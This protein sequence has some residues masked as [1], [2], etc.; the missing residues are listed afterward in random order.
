M[1]AEGEGTEYGYFAHIDRLHGRRLGF[2]IRM[3]NRAIQR[4]GL[5]PRRVVEEAANM[6][7]DPDID[8]AWAL[9]DHDRRQDILG[10][11]AEACKQ[12]VRTALSH[13]AF[14]LWLLLHFRDQ[15]PGAQGG[16][17]GGRAARTAVTRQPTYTC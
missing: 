11:C 4:N 13:P 10:V 3:P 5:S 1:V 6:A 15:L 8:E 14:E 16:H 12:A 17:N 7:D 2:H 9:F